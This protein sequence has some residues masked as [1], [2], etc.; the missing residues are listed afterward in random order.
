MIEIYAIKVPEFITESKF[1]RLLHYVSSKKKE[2][3][4]RFIRHKDAYRT[5][6]ADILIRIVIRNKFKMKIHEIK[7]D[8][9]KYGKPYLKSPN[10]FSFNLSHSGDWV[11]CVTHQSDIGVD[12]EKIQSIDLNIAQHC[13]TKEEYCDLETKQEHQQLEY[14]YDL[15]TL[16]ESYIKAIGK[17][18]H[19]PLNSFTIRKHCSNNIILQNSRI[20]NSWYFKQYELDPKY[21]LSICSMS[22]IFPDYI[23]IKDFCTLCKEIEN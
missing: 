22:N 2:Q 19:I 4:N 20:G 10:K 5:L 13:F 11:V 17:G 8:S 1:R 7:F 23:E 16:K 21:K 15:W 9:N 18:L 12:I 3:I 6:L 14:F